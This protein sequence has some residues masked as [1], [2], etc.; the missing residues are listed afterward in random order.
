LHRTAIPPFAARLAFSRLAA[1]AL[2]LMWLALV[3]AVTALDTQSQWVLLLCG[4]LASLSLLRSSGM[5]GREG[6]VS[7][8]ARG[9]CHLQLQRVALLPGCV[10]LPWLVLLR[11]RTAQKKYLTLLVWRDAV[12][13]ETHRSL[14]VYV[15]WCRTVAANLAEEEST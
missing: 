6:S 9:A 13:A 1:M 8:D 15:Q 5:A 12:P 14:R 11:G 2:L 4:L 10:A 7:V 3:L